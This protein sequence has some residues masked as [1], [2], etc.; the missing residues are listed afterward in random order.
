MLH[1]YVNWSRAAPRRARR[2]SQNICTWPSDFSE[3]RRN[4]FYINF[5]VLWANLLFAEVGPCFVH[6]LCNAILVVS[7]FTSAAKLQA[8]GE[9]KEVPKSP[10][11]A[12]AM[13]VATP[14]R[15]EGDHSRQMR[16]YSSLPSVPHSL[17]VVTDSSRCVIRTG[18]SMQIAWPA[19]DIAWSLSIEAKAPTTS[20]IATQPTSGIATAS[21]RRGPSQ[22]CSSE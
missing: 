9:E 4:S 8:Q 22:S 18:V 19:G 21:A 6:L 10:L 20:P 7:I 2:S 1:D 17:A 3:L 15:A 5:Y 13:I 14:L 11:S 16:R 12:K